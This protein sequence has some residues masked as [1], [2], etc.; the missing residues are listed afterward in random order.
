MMSVKKLIDQLWCSWNKQDHSGVQRS[1]IDLKFSEGHVTN[2]WKTT[3]KIIVGWS[4][5]IMMFVLIFKTV[6][7]RKDFDIREALKKFP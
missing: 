7:A 4:I 6:S 2:N 3:F 1:Y 5:L